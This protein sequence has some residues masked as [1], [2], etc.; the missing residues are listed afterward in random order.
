VAR[1]RAVREEASQKHV[2]EHQNLLDQA[3]ARS[4]LAAREREVLQP[5]LASAP[6]VVHLQ[7]GHGLDDLDLVA[8]GARCAVGVDFS[9]V[10]AAAAQRRALELAAHCRY[11]VAQVPA[12]P[13]LP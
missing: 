8:A 5:L 6:V 1:N 3:R 13:P 4:S 9:E 11:V 7:S 12:V 10:A 2:R